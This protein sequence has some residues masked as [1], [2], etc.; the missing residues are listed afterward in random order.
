MGYYGL[1]YDQKLETLVKEIENAFL[2]FHG[3]PKKLKVDNMKTAILCA[4]TSKY[5]IA[6]YEL[7]QLRANLQRC[8]ETFPIERFRELMGVPPGS[9][10]VARTSPAGCLISPPS[11]STAS[12]TAVSG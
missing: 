3:V 8:T 11:K 1:T 12:P 10:L 4:M 7:V 6:L 5:A 9:S 2:Y